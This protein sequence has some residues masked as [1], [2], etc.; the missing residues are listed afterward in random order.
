MPPRAVLAAV[1]CLADLGWRRIPNVVTFGGAALALV[2][3]A[4]TGGVSAFG[5]AAGGWL[6][7]LLLFL[8]LFALGGLGAGD[9]K[10]LAALGAWLGPETSFTSRSM[11]P[12]RAACSRSSLVYSRGYLRH[13][14]SQSL[15]ARDVLARGGC[16]PDGG[17]DARRGAGTATRVHA[18]DV[19]GTRRHAMAEPVARRRVRRRIDAEDGA[20][21]IEF[22]LALPLMLVLVT[23][24]FDFGLAFQQYEVVTNAAREGARLGSLGAGYLEADIQARVDAYCV[25]A[26]L[27]GG[28]PAE[29]RLGR[30]A[31]P[32]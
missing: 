4:A 28:C 3:A 26:G 2:T 5:L 25:A 23:G 31:A 7:G 16:S 6:V 8:P 21:L 18:S 10:L 14:A 30:F 15:R 22:A 24:V 13:G 9:V 11:E 32:R 12:L 19:C 29:R 20:E 27:P 17:P 1:A